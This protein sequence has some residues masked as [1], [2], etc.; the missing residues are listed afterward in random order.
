MPVLAVGVVWIVFFP[1]PW[2]AVQ[3][4]RSYDSILKAV[5][6]PIITDEIPSTV[7]PQQGV[8]V[9]VYQLSIVISIIMCVQPTH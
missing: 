2:H 3:M 6:M 7:Q 1:A 4:I 8:A 9:A 5:A